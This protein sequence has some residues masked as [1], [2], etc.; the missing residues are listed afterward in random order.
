MKI[1][2]INATT[3]KESYNQGKDALGK[4]YKT[5]KQKTEPIINET[6]AYAQNTMNPPKINV[7]REEMLAAQKK[8]LRQ[9]L[10]VSST[11]RNFPNLPMQ[12]YQQEK[13]LMK[14]ENKSQIAVEKYNKFAAREKAAQK[15]FEELNLISKTI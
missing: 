14:L 3:I 4:A 2:N 1:K 13:E 12:V 15:A 10:K 11:K 6:I 8:Y 7:L 9:T 5:V